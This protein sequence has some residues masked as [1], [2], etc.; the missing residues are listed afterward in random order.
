MNKYSENGTWSWSSA[1]A[2]I[3]GGG[4]HEYNKNDFKDLGFQTEFNVIG[5]LSD[6]TPPKIISLD[7]SP[8][9]FDVSDLDSSQSVS[10]SFTAKV[11][12]DFSGVKGIYGEWN[13][14]SGDQ[15]I[16]AEYGYYRNEVGQI[17]SGNKNYGG[18]ESDSTKHNAQLDRRAEPGVWI[19]DDLSVSDFSDNKIIYDMYDLV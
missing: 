16:E 19:L 17:V 7:Y 11:S 13:S 12:D 8:D 3:Y 6:T 4:D 18:L 5:G 15:E 9:V 10:F 1:N 2:S 14:P